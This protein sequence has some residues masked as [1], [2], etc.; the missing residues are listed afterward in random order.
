MTLL[1]ECERSPHALSFFPITLLYYCL[2]I[3][4]VIYYCAT[5]FHHSSM[6][7]LSTGS[8]KENLQVLPQNSGISQNMVQCTPTTP[9]PVS[10]KKASWKPVDDELLLECLQQQQAADHQSDT[11]FKPVAWTACVLALKDSEKRSGGSPKTAKG[12]K[13]HFGT[14]SVP[15][16]Y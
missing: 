2:Y 8:D 7:L 9:A 4:L 16:R 10:R 1:P 15:I 14:V 12:C 13:D 3:F 6:S 11:G 5:H